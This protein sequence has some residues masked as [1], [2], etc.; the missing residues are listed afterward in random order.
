MESLTDK[1]DTKISL[2]GMNPSEISSCLQLK[3]GFQAKQ[4][5]RWITRGVKSFSEMTDLPASLRS[6]LEESSFC[7]YTTEVAAVQSDDDGTVK[8]GLRLFDGSIIE[9]V[10]LRDKTDG[11]TACLSSQ[12]GCAMG[13]KFCR[14]GTLK[15]RRSLT[16][17]EICEQFLLLQSNAPGKID[18]V[19]F[20]GM[21]EPFAN[22]DNVLKAV[23]FL[24]DEN[25][26]NLSMRRITISTCGVV[27]G[28]NEL[29]KRRVPVKLAVSLV[30]ADDTIRSSIMPVNRAYNL[31]TLKAALKNFQSVSGRRFTFEY[32]MIKNVNIS[33]LDARKLASFCKSL[34][35]IVNLIPFN[36]C[37]ELDFQTPSRE[38]INHFCRKLDELGVPYTIRISRGR[39]IKGACGQL[40]GKLQ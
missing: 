38:E 20:M 21:G 9:C 28:I 16:Y 17:G 39:G 8:L 33:D 14:T 4:I 40:A 1:T 25:G 10:L 19:V 13:C 23:E 35:V 3:K 30:S 31:S 29:A 26:I 37:P 34:T 5:Y 11:L 7:L 6:S 18:H 36:P 12:S 2:I 22:I 27:P 15:L 32:C 24:H